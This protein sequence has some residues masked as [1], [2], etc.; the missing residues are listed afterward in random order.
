V[1]IWSLSPTWFGISKDVLWRGDRIKLI[2][3]Q[4]KFLPY[5]V[6]F[7][8][9]YT[10]WWTCG[11]QIR[12]TLHDFFPWFLPSHTYSRSDLFPSSGCY[13]INARCDSFLSS[14]T[15]KN[16]KRPRKHYKYH[17]LVLRE[18]APEEEGGSKGSYGGSKLV[19]LFEWLNL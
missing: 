8:S 3:F 19:L 18:G 16:P 15:K 11:A 17:V 4:S 7:L 6:D 2:F 14:T 1:R 5:T 13:A 10:W 9:I 12:M